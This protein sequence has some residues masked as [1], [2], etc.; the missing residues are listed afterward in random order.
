MAKI[1]NSSMKNLHGDGNVKIFT[2]NSGKEYTI[3]NTGMKNLHGDG[4][5]QKVEER[6][7]TQYFGAGNSIMMTILFISFFIL[8]LNLFIWEKDILY[9]IGFIGMAGSIVIDT[10]IGFFTGWKQ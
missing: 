1:R 7:S 10:L 8:V 6:G 3:S 5:E 9:Q 4:Y 2:D